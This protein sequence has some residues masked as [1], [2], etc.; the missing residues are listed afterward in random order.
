MQL[1]G[2]LNSYQL[3]IQVLKELQLVKFETKYRGNHKLF[4][5]QYLAN[6]TLK[7]Y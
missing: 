7:A 1:K 2:I 4:L 6:G 3:A 5:A